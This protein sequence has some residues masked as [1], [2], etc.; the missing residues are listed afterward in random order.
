MVSVPLLTERM[1]VHYFEE[2]LLELYLQVIAR[3]VRE[4]CFHNPAPAWLFFSCLLGGR[5]VRTGFLT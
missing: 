5:F 4:F 1:G 2:N 3:P